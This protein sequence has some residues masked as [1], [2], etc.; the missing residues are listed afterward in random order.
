MFSEVT[1]LIRSEPYA[2][3]LETLCFFLDECSLDEAPSLEDVKLWRDILQQRGGKF[4]KLAVLCENFLKD[5]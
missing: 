5:N 2:D 4:L 1:S 3:V